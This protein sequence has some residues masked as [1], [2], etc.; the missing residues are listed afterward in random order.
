MSFSFR[1]ACQGMLAMALLLACAQPVQAQK[2]KPAS[3]PSPKP[4][5]PAPPIYVTP[6]AVV[7]RLQ[8]FVPRTYAKL[9]ERKPVHI[10]TVGDDLVDMAGSADDA[11]NQIAVL[12]CAL[13]R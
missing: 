11:G 3:T 13:R 8:K 10:V 9:S 4:V 12:A 5:E 6:P 2:P 7:V 1:S